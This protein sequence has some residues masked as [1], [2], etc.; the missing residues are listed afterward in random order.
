[1]SSHS[2]HAQR[3]AALYAQLRSTSVVVSIIA[4]ERSCFCNTPYTVLMRAHELLQLRSKYRICF[5]R[6]TMDA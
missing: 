5:F 4:D 3:S 1:M 2:H 6:L